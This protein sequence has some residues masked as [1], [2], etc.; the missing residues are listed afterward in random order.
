MNVMSCM[1]INIFQTLT[2]YLR[3][4]DTQILF[5]KII[6]HKMYQ[7]QICNILEKYRTFQDNS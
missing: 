1:V 2:R 4:N 3:K 6:V 5:L 7:Y